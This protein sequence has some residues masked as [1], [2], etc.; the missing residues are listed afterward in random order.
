MGR[1]PE[2]SPKEQQKFANERDRKVWL[3]LLGDVENFTSTF[4]THDIDHIDEQ[5]LRTIIDEITDKIT[6]MPMAIVSN[7]ILS[8]KIRTRK[9]FEIFEEK[10]QSCE[11]TGTKP[12]PV[13]PLIFEKIA[14]LIFEKNL[15]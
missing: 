8:V 5:L 15:V 7:S 12:N 10:I 2:L 9:V 13:G 11:A 1:Y 6:P 3:R 14:P 4:P